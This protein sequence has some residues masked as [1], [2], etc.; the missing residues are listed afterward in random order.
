MNRFDTVAKDWDNKPARQDMTKAISKAIKEHVSLKN[1]DILDY[2]CGTGLL[3]FS[4]SD[5]AKSV[6]GMDSSF[7]MIEVFNQKVENFGF[8]N[9]K[10]IFFNIEKEDLPSLK[11]DIIVTS[12]TLHHIK[13][14]TIFFEKCKKALKPNGYL[15]ITDL[16]EENG[17]FHQKND[18]VYHFG[19]SKKEVKEFYEN[20]GFKLSFIE[21]IHTINRENGDFQIFLSIGQI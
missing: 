6:V 9:I 5:E 15:C 12:M 8:E 3:A 14:P 4:I 16:D 17:S 10:A 11:Y 21:N 20:S 2:G 18:D 7:G 13:S 19:F 1:K